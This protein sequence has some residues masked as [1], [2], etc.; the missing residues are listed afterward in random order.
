[1]KN[2]F[3]SFCKGKALLRKAIID[4]NE[5]CLILSFWRYGFCI[6]LIF[7][8]ESDKELKER[9]NKISKEEI[10]SYIKEFDKMAEKGQPFG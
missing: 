5:P 2:W 10:K 1:M 4:N 6:E 7:V 8:F 9:F 3:K